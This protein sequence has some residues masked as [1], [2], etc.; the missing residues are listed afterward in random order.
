MTD[1]FALKTY[2]RLFGE[3]APGLKIES[4]SVPR[5]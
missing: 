5:A 2:G 3:S 1:M 4:M